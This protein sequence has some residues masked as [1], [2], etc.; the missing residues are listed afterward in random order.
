MRTYAAWVFGAAALFN[1][2]VGLA[3][4]FARP[5]LAQ[6]LGL[7]PVTGTGVLF[8]DLT[9]GFILLF[10]YAYFRIA[11]APAGFERVITLSA[12]GKVMAFAITVILWATHAIP[13]KVPLL[14]GGDLVLAALFLDYLRR[15]ARPAPG[16]LQ[17]H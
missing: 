17:T 3:L 15:A 6:A 12:A 14:A 1:A 10:A 5:V 11:L 13:A 9:A 8:A 16:A 7:D 2:A 4:L